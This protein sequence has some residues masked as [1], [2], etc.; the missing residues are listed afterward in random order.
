MTIP[1]QPAW[2]RQVSSTVRS[3]GVRGGAFRHVLGIQEACIPIH[4]PHTLILRNPPAARPACTPVPTVAPQ[5]T[6]V[7]CY[8]GRCRSMRRQAAG[9][10]ENAAWHSIRNHRHGSALVAELEAQVEGAWNRLPGSRA[11][12]LQPGGPWPPG[13]RPHPGSAHLCHGGRTS[14][15]TSAPGKER[16]LGPALLGN[17]NNSMRNCKRCCR[18]LILSK[19]RAH[20]KD[21]DKA[22]LRTQ[23]RL[24]P[25]SGWICSY[26]LRMREFRVQNL[27]LE[28]FGLLR[29]RP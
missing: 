1:G 11:R 10:L 5:I 29:G 20:R 28:G 23:F 12:L 16:R 26:G 18:R 25:C 7:F 4:H 8:S 14:P 9:T 3:N 27:G 24:S 21:C 2:E 22:W 17:S 6:E 19:L 15:P 13:I